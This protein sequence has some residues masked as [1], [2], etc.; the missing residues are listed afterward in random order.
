[1]N[2]TSDKLT[3]FSVKSAG[4]VWFVINGLQSTHDMRFLT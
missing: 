3:M 4:A 2:K 1:M